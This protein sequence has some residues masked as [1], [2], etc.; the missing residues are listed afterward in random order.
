MQHNGILC[1]LIYLKVAKRVDPESS[2]QEEIK[3]GGHYMRLWMLTKL[4]VLSITQY[5][6]KVI[7][8]YTLNLQGGMSIISEKKMFLYIKI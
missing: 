1:C 2:H 3:N 4:P 5:I 8:L 6:C 7:M